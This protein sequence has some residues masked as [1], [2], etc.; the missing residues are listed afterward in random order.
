VIQARRATPSRL[1]LIT[2]PISVARSSYACKY[3]ATL[4][5]DMQ[6]IKPLTLESETRSR[7]TLNSMP[8]MA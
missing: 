2:T 6:W 1:R 4:G 7:K 5:G 8:L 3:F